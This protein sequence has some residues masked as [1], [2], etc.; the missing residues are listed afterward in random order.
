MPTTHSTSSSSAHLHKVTSWLGVAQREALISTNQPSTQLPFQRWF[1]FKE[2]FAPQLVLDVLRKHGGKPVERC[3]DPFGGCGTTGLTCQFVGVHP[4]LIEVNPF[5][6]DL[7]EAKLATYDVDRLTTDFVAVRAGARK[8]DVSSIELPAGAP[9]T[10][11]EP[12]DRKRW[13]FPKDVLD[14]ILQYRTVIDSIEDEA[15]RRLLRVLLGSVVVGV[16]NVTVNGKGRKYRGSWMSQQRSAH[17]VDDAFQAAFLNA[18]NDIARYGKRAKSTYEL[19][20]GTCL[21][22]L[23][24]VEPCDLALF[25][26]PYPNSFDYTDIYN[27]ELWVLGYLNTRDDNKRLRQATLRSHVQAGGQH[28]YTLAPSTMLRQTIADLESKKEHLWDNRLPDMIGAYFD[29][30]QQLLKQLRTTLRPGGRAVIVIGESSY[31]GI[32]VRAGHIA[33]QIAR[34][35]GFDVER[36]SRLRTMRLS[37]Q[38]GGDHKL[39][40]RLLELV[41]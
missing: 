36:H 18:V 22:R 29:D 14:R 35:V 7:A 17:E 34:N 26:P 12:G 32:R 28:T 16:S 39:E 9:A 41:N 37:A 4:V 21:Q 5:I 13:V 20:R 1:K 33:A 40:E 8:K 27:L 2:A 11:C 31:A 10:L 15:N 30:M 6:A 25:S 19:L 24:Q 23:D 38:Q 3:I